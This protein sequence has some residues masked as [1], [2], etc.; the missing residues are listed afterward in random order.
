MID[1]RPALINEMNVRESPDR[2]LCFVRHERNESDATRLISILS[3]LRI[4]DQQRKASRLRFPIQY[5]YVY[6][7]MRAREEKLNRIFSMDVKYEL[8]LIKRVAFPF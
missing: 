3:K 8:K 5:D 7:I 2:R 6:V 1:S 4:F